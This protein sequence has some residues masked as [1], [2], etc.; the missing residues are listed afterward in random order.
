MVLIITLKNVY[1]L[2]SYL[3][4]FPLQHNDKIIGIA[5]KKINNYIINWFI[6]RKKPAASKK[7]LVVKFT[8]LKTQ[9]TITAANRLENVKYTASSNKNCKI[10]N[11]N[12][13]P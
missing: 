13:L 4:Y 6:F 11:C 3:K 10:N 1:Q 7:P 8:L 2:K 5:V 12:S 9:T